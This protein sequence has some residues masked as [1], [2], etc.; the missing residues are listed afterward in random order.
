M[1][2]FFLLA[3]VTIPALAER[4]DLAVDP[5]ATVVNWALGDVLHTV[6]GTF[7][8]KK[9]DLW[10]DPVTGQ[11]GGLLVVDAASGESGSSARDGR[12]HKNV[13]E[14]ARYPEITFVPDRV[15]GSITPTGDSAGQLHGMFTIHGATHEVLMRVKS[16]IEQQELK[17]SISFIVPYVKWG[18]KDPSNFLLKVKDFVEVDIEAAARISASV[19]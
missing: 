2:L 15:E 13:L 18:M 12:M 14:S 8:L 10:F 11:A 17:A 19:R 7:H 3:L 4:I 16:H 5:A 9:G 6:H 1:N